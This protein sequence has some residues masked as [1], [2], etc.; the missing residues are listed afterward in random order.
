MTNKTGYYIIFYHYR[1]CY[2]FKFILC[3]Y[4]FTT[5]AIRCG[6]TD[7]PYMQQSF[8]FKICNIIE[9]FVRKWE[10]G[11]FVENVIE[12]EEMEIRKF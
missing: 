9:V 5:N 4:K 8:A 11:N 3:F 10:K 6:R 1:N 7:T 12:R 2:V